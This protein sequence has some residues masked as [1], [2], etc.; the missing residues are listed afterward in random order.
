MTGLQLVSAILRKLEVLASGEVPS[1]DEASDTLSAVNLLLSG[2]SNEELT[3][4]QTVEEAF[5]LT[6][7]DDS[8]TIGSGGDFDTSRPQSIL[9]AAIRSGSGSN[10]TDYPVE[11]REINDWAMIPSK[12]VQSSI[13]WEL[14]Q[15]GGYPLKTIQ[16]YPVPSEA[17]ALVLWS[18][19]PL[20]EIT[21][22]ST[23]LSF[24]PGYERALIYNGAIEAAPEFGREPSAAVVKIARESLATIKSKN[25][26]PARL[27]TD[28]G[29]GRRYDIQS[30]RYR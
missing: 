16:L 29:R 18:K 2:W 22:L 30:G 24:P 15:N 7:G 28:M 23:T 8:Y 26:K 19:K 9:K 5:T 20:T 11:V 27:E 10:Q 21:S 3:I 4:F 25:V 14:Y 1:G 12:K 6:A 17:N 13:P